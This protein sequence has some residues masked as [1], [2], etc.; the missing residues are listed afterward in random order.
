MVLVVGSVAILDSGIHRT[1]LAACYF[2]S[3]KTEQIMPKWQIEYEIAPGIFAVLDSEQKKLL[4]LP[5]RPLR[6]P[7]QAM[8]KKRSKRG[9]YKYHEKRT[10]DA[11]GGI[12]RY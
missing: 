11:G 2:F 4:G 10:A 6:M 3:E 12:S 8:P 7:Y 9:P 1:F 5:P